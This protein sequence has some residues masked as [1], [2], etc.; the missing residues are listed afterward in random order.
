MKQILITGANGQLGNCIRDYEQLYPEWKFLYTD[1]TE[2]D[3]CNSAAINKFFESHEIH[4]IVNC[5][6]FTAVDKAEEEP[7]LCLKINKD[8]V[9]ELGHA[10][11]E[12]GAKIIHISTDYVF[13]GNNCRPYVETDE[14]NPI[15][16]YGMTKL[17]GEKALLSVCPQAIILRTAWLYSEYGRNFVKTM[18]S[19]AKER[20]EINVVFDQIGTPTYAG[21]LAKAILSII[22]RSEEGKWNNGIYHVSN[23]GVCSWYDFALKIIEIS[24]LQCSVHPIESKDYP[25]KAVRP[26]FSVLNKRK[27]KETYPEIIIPHWEESLIHCLDKLEKLK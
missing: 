10:A 20:K 6:A 21:D 4:Y 17:E 13:D 1:I 5:A 18:R 24:L 15:S 9:S 12:H 2:L 27:I 19:L 8:A 3:L 22:Q 16:V 14:T 7:E 25:T 23:E 11:M 26:C